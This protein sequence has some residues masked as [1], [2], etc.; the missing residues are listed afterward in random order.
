MSAP[1]RTGWIAAFALALAACAAPQPA[2]LPTQQKAVA[3]RIGHVFVIVLE[4]QPFERSFGK[5]SPA[6]YLAHGLTAQGAL[7]RQYFGIGHFSLGN[8]IAMVSGQA[9]NPETQRD[10]RVF[11]EFVATDPQLDADGQLHGA[12]CVYP[13]QVQ[14][15]A[16]QLEARQL[17]WRGYMED[18]GNDPA[19][20]AAACGHAAIGSQD[21][22]N[23]A[24]PGDQYADK[25]NP[26][27]YFH[28]IIDDRARCERHVVNLEA[29]RTDLVSVATTPNFAFITPN[30]CH[31]GHDRPC[32]NGEPGGLESADVFLRA[33]VPRILESAAFKQD[34]LLVITFDEGVDDSSACCDERP[35]AGGPA[36]GLFGPGGGRVGAV[37]ISPSIRPGSVSDVPYNHYSLLRWIEDA[38]QLPHLG[39]AAAPGLATF[40]DDVFASP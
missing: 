20:E 18:M 23:H 36:P 38:F 22:T 25:H 9:P 28:S 40:G 6:P 10:C 11:S 19:R 5:D 1:R 17:T 26:F 27:V 34:G 31:D 4:N 16:D 29:L 21:A 30:M 32:K 39:Y 2:P 3:P 35:L 12:G 13:V 37:L 7:L 24:A 33:W 14:T 15:V 8:Y